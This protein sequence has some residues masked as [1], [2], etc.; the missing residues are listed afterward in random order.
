MKIQYAKENLMSPLYTFY[1]QFGL[2]FLVL[3]AATNL[4]ATTELQYGEDLI[5]TIEVEGEIDTYTFNGNAGDV[6]WIRMRDAESPIDA[7]MELRNPAGEVIGEDCR[8]GGVVNIRHFTLPE[9]GTYEIIVS[10]NRNNDTGDYGLALE[11]L[12]SPQAAIPIDCG[13][14]LAGEIGN[15]VEIK[16][17]SFSASAGEVALFRMR[18]SNKSLE[19]EI[20]I[21]DPAG[22]L[23]ADHHSS[24]LARVEG[25]V[26]PETGTYLVMVTD[27]NGNDTGG[28]GLSFQVLNRL[29]CIP[30][31]QCGE[32]GSDFGGTSPAA[33]YSIAELAEVDA[34]RFKAQPGDKIVAQMFSPVKGFEVSIR[35]YDGDGNF[36]TKAAPDYGLVRLEADDF[37]S[38]GEYVLLVCDNNGN[39]RSDYDLFLEKVNNGGCGTPIHCI[40]NY[41][42]GQ[43]KAYGAMRSY[44]F[45]SVAGSTTN[46]VIRPLEQEGL[47]PRLELYSP[48]GEQLHDAFSYGSARLEDFVLPEDGT[49][50]VLVSDK[51]GNDLGDYEFEIS[52]DK[53]VDTQAPVLVCKSP[54]DRYL[55]EDGALTLDPAAWIEEAFDACSNVTVAVNV[56]DFTCDHIGTNEVV[57]SVTD[58]SGNTTSHTMYVNI[59]DPAAHC[60]ADYCDATGTSASYEWIEK[61]S[62]ANQGKSSGNNNGY[63][64]FVEN[65]VSLYRNVDYG[66]ALT[67]GYSDNGNY[68]D[69]FW[70]VWIDWN[71]DGDF[72]DEGETILQEQ[73]Q[74]IV[75]TS[76]TTPV[77][78][79]VSGILMRVT[80][81]YGSAPNSCGTF[82]YGET[83][84]YLLRILEDPTCDE[85]PEEWKVANIGNTPIPGSVCYNPET[86]TYNVSGSGHD[87]YGAADAFYYIYQE[88]CGD[89]DIVVKLDE[90]SFPA[91]GALAGIMFRRNLKAGSKN[92]SLVAT[93]EHGILYQARQKNNKGTIYEAHEGEAPAWI[94]LERRGNLFTGYI[95]KD[96]EEWELV[97]PFELAFPNCITVGIAVSSNTEETVNEAVFS[98]VS[99]IPA[100]GASL[101]NGP[102]SELSADRND[103]EEETTP[104]S[105][106][107]ELSVFP[108][109]VVDYVQIDCA[110][111]R[112]QATNIQLFSLTGSLLWQDQ[113]TPAGDL[114]N[115]DFGR[116]N[117][118]QGTYFLQVSTGALQTTKKVLIQ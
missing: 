104:S 105:T 79:P 71:R 27:Y 49:Y 36:L 107:A 10:D 31:I 59:E 9:T 68:E 40:G 41:D 15:S 97:C 58:E 16:A 100:P 43:L 103:T 12:N 70:A 109:P 53:L 14:D 19:S 76:F 84:D 24:H 85:L 22:N 44:T 108:N 113:T 35:L 5:A 45:T 115:Y 92:I 61:V 112:D 78:A 118:P 23:I 90:A 75:K 42:G 17:Y 101:A 117:L 28:Y 34:Y 47:D 52:A 106:L 4:Q 114:M 81:Q 21:Y 18:S 89:G 57:I 3:L 99:V 6:I 46:I 67:P 111:C 110:A 87:I 56:V 33:D 72:D 93:K 95:S 86:E 39:D 26:F 32:D 29:S 96:G 77:D 69:R 66:I 65:P 37:D 94:K 54:E 20:S 63:A 30:V 74:S 73:S 98:N 91:T 83:E 25:L 38:A 64:S 55:L 8:D 60:V 51:N 82:E 88:L 13:D 62:F 116:L 48:S 2:A 80:Y 102:T 50:T 1:Q 11:I 7:C